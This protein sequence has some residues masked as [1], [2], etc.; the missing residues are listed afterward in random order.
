MYMFLKKL[1]F[2]YIQKKEVKN[3]EVFGFVDIY[4]Y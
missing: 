2:K 3:D 1:V 4:G